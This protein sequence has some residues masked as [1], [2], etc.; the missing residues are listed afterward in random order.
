MAV[1]WQDGDSSSAKGFRH[2]YANE[3]ESKVMLCGGPVGRAHGK[4]LEELR[5]KSS[6]TSAFITL[7]KEQFPS[8]YQDQL[9]AV[10]PAKI[11]PLFLPGTNLLVV[12]LAQGLYKMPS[13]TTTVHWCMLA[14]VP[15]NTGK[16]C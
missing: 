6:F 8:S 10:V 16:Q 7:H 11:T 5:T 9:N 14:T 4:K 1:N 12:V 2:S 13:E 15:I 3:Q